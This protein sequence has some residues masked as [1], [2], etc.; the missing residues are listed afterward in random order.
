M[1]GV[2]GL[3]EGKQHCQRGTPEFLTRMLGRARAYIG[4]IVAIAKYAD[5]TDAPIKNGVDMVFNI[6]AEAGAGAAAHMR[7]L[8]LPDEP[9][10]T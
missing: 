3:R 7:S 5:E 10:A 1:F 2:F 6:Y 8:M 4:P 9:S